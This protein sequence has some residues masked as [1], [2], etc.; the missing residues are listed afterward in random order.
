MS[1]QVLTPGAEHPTGAV[2]QAGVVIRPLAGL[3]SPAAFFCVDMVFLR[4]R[5]LNR[6]K[7]IY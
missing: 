2:A 1:G 6:S 3:S 7:D 4:K 5:L